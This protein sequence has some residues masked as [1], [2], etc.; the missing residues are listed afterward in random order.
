MIEPLFVFVIYQQIQTDIIC[1]T[2]L[3]FHIY[4]TASPCFVLL[5]LP[6][7]TSSSFFL[8]LLF[9]FVLFVFFLLFLLLFFLSGLEICI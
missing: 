6:F 7:H 2:N 9:L 5:L 8:F 1:L 3:F 4:H